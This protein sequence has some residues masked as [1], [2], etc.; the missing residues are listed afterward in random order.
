MTLAFVLFCTALG[1]MLASF[2]GVISERLYTGESWATD[3]SRCNSCGRR[4]G[5]L[6]LVPILS[7][8][9]SRGRCR[10]CK[11]S[12]PYRY[13]LSEVGLALVF[14]A[15]AATL[16]AGPALVVF[17]AT[18]FVLMIIVLYDLRHTVVPLPLSAV[19][20]GLCALYAYLTTADLHALS[21]TFLIAGIIGLGFFLMHFLSGGRWMG[22]GD[23]PIALAL[24]LLAGT[25]AIA[26]LLF[27]FWIG[28][29]IG[30]VILVRAREGHRMGIEV[31]FVPF[32]AAGYLLAFFTQWNP[33]ILF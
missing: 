11:A 30:I 21:L 25:Q 32:L 10:T 20:I 14:Y 9:A 15:A 33:F 26:G 27:S 24:S 22:L 4:L 16:S 7:W 28:A 2:A 17:F 5:V 8:L 6:D 31:P 29:A 13:A 3:H 12:V 1:A 23:A 19:L 18:S